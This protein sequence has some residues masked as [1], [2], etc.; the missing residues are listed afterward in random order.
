MLAASVPLPLSAV[1]AAS[2]AVHEAGVD[3]QDALSGMIA[4]GELPGAHAVVMRGGARDIEILLGKADVEAARPLAADAIYR[5]Y[6]MSKPVTSIAALM[7]VEEGRIALD[8]PISRYLPEMAHL[9]VYQEGDGAAMTTRPPARDVTVRDL[10]MHTAGFTYVF[11]GD[12]PVQHYYRDH[13]V[14]RVTAV[15]SGPAGVPPAATLDEL[16]A[17]LGDAPLLHDPGERFSYG[18]ST[19]VLGALVAR[20]AGEPLPLFLKRRIFDPLE[21]PDTRFVLNEAQAARLVTNYVA[22]AGGLRPLEQGL[23]SE[24]RDPARL[25]D[26]GGALA[27]TMEDYLHFAQMLAD[28]GIW[29]GKRLLDAGLVAEMFTPRIHT[30]GDPREAA[31]FGYGLAIG[32]AR[33]QAAGGLPVGAGSWSGSANSYFL[34]QPESGTVAV[35]MTNVLTPGPF[36]DRSFALRAA[37]NAAALAVAADPAKAPR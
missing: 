5:L 27:G 8:A 29:R 10:L 2:P 22:T 21:M 11:M 1:L 33:T 17:R 30:G 3:L 26:G 9:K 20:V 15:A 28:G 24:Y 35:V 7:L 36:A 34:V 37:V 25:I 13:G 31:M 18:F 19:T 4:R 12:G 14:A 16:V 23:T 6:S 32:D